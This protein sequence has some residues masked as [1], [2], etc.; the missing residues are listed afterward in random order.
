MST[1]LE[2]PKSEATVMAKYEITKEQI[3]KAVETAS[4]VVV[5]GPDDKKGMALAREN[6][7]SLQKMRTSIEAKRKDLKADALAFGKKVD[8]VAKELTALITPEES[9]LKELEETAAREAER[10]AELE[11]KAREVENKRRCD[12][13]AKINV[14]VPVIELSFMDTDAFNEFYAQKRIAF[15]AAEKAKA[16]EE[17]ARKA[18]AERLAKQAEEQAAQAAEIA[19]QQAEW[20]KTKAAHDAEIDRQ[21]AE[22]DAKQKAIDDAEREKREKCLGWRTSQLAFVN[23]SMPVVE[24]MAMSDEEFEQ[25]VVVMRHDNE[26]RIEEA[27]KAEAVRKEQEAKAEAERIAKA[28]KEEADRIERERL[29]EIARKE[30]EAKS[31]KEE[32]ARIAALAPDR[33]KID[34]YIC[35]VND[36]AVPTLS[37]TESQDKLAYIV[38]EF[39]EDLREMIA[40]LEKGTL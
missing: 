11:K 19:R 35:F 38:S 9:R 16:D 21:R 15:D 36:I 22:I 28:A 24:M 10:I 17:A 39:I 40:E 5:S 20:E 25:H 8:S 33:E 30:A 31:A 23:A 12:V 4:L 1:V 29:A 3:K 14:M 13:L 27:A 37:T 18:E 2:A 34:A 32:A 7:L 6:R 26:R